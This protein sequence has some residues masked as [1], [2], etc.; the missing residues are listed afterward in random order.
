M[1]LDGILADGESV[2]HLLGGRR[3]AKD[4]PLGEWPTECNKDFSLTPGEVRCSCDR[5]S[6]MLDLILARLAEDDFG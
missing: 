6:T 4:V 5:R 1:L 2:G 3:L